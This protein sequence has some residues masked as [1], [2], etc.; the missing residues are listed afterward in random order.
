MLKDA[1][2][3]VI[4]TDSPATIAQ[5][6]RFIDQSLA[7][8]KNAESTILRALV[9][10]PTCAIAHAYAAA[11]Y[12]SQENASDRQQATS[13]LIAAQQNAVKTTEREQ[14]Y[15]RATVAWANGTISEATKLHM[16]IA[17]KYP[18]DL[19]SVQQGQYHYFYQGNAIGLLKIAQT[20][21]PSHPYRHYLYGM[22][23]FGLEQCGNLADAEAFGRQAIALN[24]HDPWAQHAVAHVFDRQGRIAAGIDWMTSHADTWSTCNSMLYTHNWWHLA[25]YYLAL[26]DTQTVLALYDQQIW[27]KAT[28]GS[29]KDQVGAIATLMRLELQGVNVGDR[30]QALA[31]Y[32]KLRLHEHSLPFQ[33]LHYVYALAR[34][35]CNEWLT[36]MLASLSGYIA[37]VSTESKSMYRE[38]VLPTAKGLVAYAKGDWAVAIAA[39]QLTLPQLQQVGGS[40]TQRQLFKSIY[41][42]ALVNARGEQTD[43][44]I[45]ARPIQSNQPCDYPRTTLNHD[46]AKHTNQRDLPKLTP[47]WMTA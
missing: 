45:P 1:Q 41:Q 38:V 28:P 11:Y 6:D 3:L 19:I 27:G 21:L 33:D 16:A 25:L 40:Y 18:Q 47:A 29:P 4:T 22:L 36:E 9:T 34:A 14:W 10:D 20:V 30:W 24:R 39:L 8:S 13:H 42:A 23:A 2:D 37:V 17:Q 12:L 35:E 43:Q 5:I 46:H 26:G 31:P 7:Y 15:I 32:L 44:I